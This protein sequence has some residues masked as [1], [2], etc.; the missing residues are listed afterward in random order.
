MANELEFVVTYTGMDG[1]C[2]EEPCTGDPPALM[3]RITLLEGLGAHSVSAETIDGDLVYEQ[4]GWTPG[5]KIK[6]WRPSQAI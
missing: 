3:R 5:L 1:L 4:G 2:H 6:A